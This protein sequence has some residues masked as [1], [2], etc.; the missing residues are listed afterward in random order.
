MCLHE[1]R[2]PCFGGLLGLHVIDVDCRDVRGVCRVSGCNLQS[3]RNDTLP[4]VSTCQH[5][6]SLKT[7]QAPAKPEGLR[8]RRLSCPGSLGCRQLE[9]G[10]DFRAGGGHSR[11]CSGLEAGFSGARFGLQRVCRGA[12]RGQ[13]LSSGPCRAPPAQNRSSPEPVY[14]LHAKSTIS[15]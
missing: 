4:L 9:K 10:T 2:F 11:S 5:A 1:P 14:H 6:W 3:T 15:S 13:C 8:S 12:P 7:L